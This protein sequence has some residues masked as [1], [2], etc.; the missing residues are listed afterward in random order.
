MTEFSA[1]SAVRRKMSHLAV[2]VL[3]LTLTNCTKFKS[4]EVLSSSE[5]STSIAGANVLPVCVG[6]CGI[7]SSKLNLLNSPFVSVTVCVPGTTQC[8]TIPNILLSTTTVGL[9]IFS[10][11][12]SVSL[13]PVTAAD[14][15]PV[16]E[17]APYV[18]GST[19]SYTLWGPVRTADVVLGAEAPVTVPI[20]ILEPGFGTL[21]AACASPADT[22]ANCDYRDTP[23]TGGTSFD[24][25]NSLLRTVASDGWEA[26]SF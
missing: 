21:P 16:G 13:P 20:Q 10:S 5:S 22:P 19:T 12:L 9:R 26:P 17:C 18:F 1:L 4:S 6:N 8:Q 7:K 14:G 15:Q 24:I 25:V 3:G 2:A 23:C 11:E